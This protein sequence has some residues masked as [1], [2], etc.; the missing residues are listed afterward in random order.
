M[1]TVIAGVNGAGKS[2]IPGA[3]IEAAGGQ[4][5]NPDVCAR[6]LMLR[7]PSIS[8][9]SANSQAWKI[10]FE[11]LKRSI[12]HDDDYAFETTLGGNSIVQTLIE[13]GQAGRQIQVFYCGLS[14]PELHIERVAIRVARGGHSIPE[15]TIRERWKSSILNMMALVPVCYRV[16][17]W[18]NSIN[19]DRG[20]PRPVKLMSF[21]QG[22]FDPGGE[23]SR[24]L[25][26]WAKPLAAAVLKAGVVR[27]KL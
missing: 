2:S 18:D 15:Q 3:R 25:P 20:G 5:Y 8:L 23:P 1:I 9:A 19:A 11:Q 12:A 17:V 21:T 7:D 10:G 27:S 22:T 16:Q 24:A 13:A 26:S 4:Y 6:Q 14:S